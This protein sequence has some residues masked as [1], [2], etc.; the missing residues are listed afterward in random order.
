MKLLSVRWLVFLA[1]LP[2]AVRVL[3]KNRCLHKFN[4]LAWKTQKSGRVYWSSL[5]GNSNVPGDLL[6]T[7]NSKFN[8]LLWI[9]K[10][11]SKIVCSQQ[12]EH[13]S[14][15]FKEL[16]SLRERLNTF[17]CCFWEPELDLPLW[18]WLGKR[19]RWLQEVVRLWIYLI[20]SGSS[21]HHQI[22]SASSGDF[23]VTI[24]LIFLGV[25]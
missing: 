12:L 18:V 25:V 5:C 11:I 7:G 6:L 4:P 13:L 15:I 3:L 23:A 1:L 17:S 24:A 21:F 19:R 10:K 2:D 16:V 22:P 8:I 14:E 20:S 9:C